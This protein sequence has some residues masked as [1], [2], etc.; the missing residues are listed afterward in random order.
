MGKQICDK[1]GKEMFRKALSSAS[2]PALYADSAALSTATTSTSA[3]P[4][5]FSHSSCS[6]ITDKKTIKVSTFIC[7]ECKSEKQTRDTYSE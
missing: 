5:F 7:P 1:C 3:A 2:T 4:V 6:P